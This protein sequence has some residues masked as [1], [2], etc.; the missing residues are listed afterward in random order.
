MTTTG[1]VTAVLLNLGW[2]RV[3]EPSSWRSKLG[4]RK[5]RLVHTGQSSPVGVAVSMSANAFRITTSSL[6]GRGDAS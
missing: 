6:S 2:P 4:H 5:D 1:P 3:K